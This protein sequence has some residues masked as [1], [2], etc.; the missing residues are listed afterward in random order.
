MIDFDFENINSPEP[1]RVLVSEPF[2]NDTFFTRSVIYL[3]DYSPGGSFGFVLNN[4]METGLKELIPDF[5]D[6]DIRVSIGGPVDEG[7]LYFIHSLGDKIPNSQKIVGGLS[8]GGTFEAVK[9][10]L[11]ENKENAKYFRFFIGYSGWDEGQLDSELEEKSWVVLKKFSN[12]I[13]LDDG[14]DDLWKDLM[15]KMGGKFEV[16]SNF[17]KNPSD[18]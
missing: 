13:I 9:E 18:N 12:D 16:M 6:V 8:I 5:P 3:C 14:K 7:N 2:L 10:L 1:G 11:I 4:F 15:A 17:P